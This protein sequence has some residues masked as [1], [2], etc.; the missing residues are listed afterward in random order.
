M[1]NQS[2]YDT[3]LESL[4]SE[5]KLPEHFDLA[6]PKADPNEPVFIPGAKDGISV[7]HFSSIKQKTAAA[8][9]A[10]HL[11][12]DWQAGNFNSL[13]SIL[14]LLNT[15]GTLTVI[16]TILEKIEER[17]EEI[18]VANVVDYACHLAFKASDEELVKLGIGLISLLDFSSEPQTLAKLIKLALYDEFTFFVVEALADYDNE[19]A[20]LFEIAQK[21]DGWGKIHTVKKLEP[22]SEEIRQWILRKG[23][24]NT[25]M[26]AYLGLECATKGDLVNAL[27]QG[28]IDEEIFEGA[29][30]IINALIDEGPQKGIS[31]YQHTEEVLE[32]YLHFAAKQATTVKHLWWL[33]NLGDWLNS[34]DIAGKE[35]LISTCDSIISRTSWREKIYAI[36]DNPHCHQLFYVD[37]IA[38]RIDM[39]IAEPMFRAIKDNPIDCCGFLSV[40]FEKPEYA[41]EL[42]NVYEKI[43][44]LGEM[45]T[46]MGNLLFSMSL[47]EEHQC[48]EFVLEELVNYPLSSEI[49]VRTGLQ[50]P[51]VRDRN[52]ACKVL[53]EWC[54]LLKQTLKTAS[55]SLYGLLKDIEIIE[56]DD[57]NRKCMRKLL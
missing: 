35:A 47:A 16:D 37:N 42:V 26:D 34:A 30:I 50:S 49:L 28:S 12:T 53:T 45:A 39:D 14:E 5:G 22:V 3:I 11:I 23:C 51:V 56:V 9:I 27:R 13:N 18:E 29:G 43:L 10:D 7:F 57:N 41:Q 20:M 24:T 6:K 1:A 31:V 54:K 21:V 36:F 38:R 33:L 17:K 46:G 25:I 44:P 2:I 40:V 15:Y 52:I 55:P 32:R 48:L 19:Q 8:T 4:N